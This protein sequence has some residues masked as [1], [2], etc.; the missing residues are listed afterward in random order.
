MDTNNWLKDEINK[1]HMQIK[2]ININMNKK[3]DDLKNII[4]EKDI[5]I[6]KL[7]KKLLK[8]K[9]RLNELNNI[10]IENVVNKNGINLK[11]FRDGYS[12]ETKIFGDKFVKN[13][14]DNIELM[15]NGDKTKLIEKAELHYGENNIKIILK[16]KLENLEEMFK[17]CNSLLNIEELKYLDVSNVKN[18]SYM[19]Y[20]CSRLSDIKSL[21]NWNV[22]N[23][24]NFSYMLSR[25]YHLSDIK[26]LENWKTKNKIFKISH[27][28]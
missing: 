21:K 3:E 25:R 5:L 6:K 2:E 12:W 11:Y 7:E 4:E 26:S 10:L 19:F 15:I 24:N 8:Q 16:N 27:I 23:G 17:G 22:S 1:I 14:Q 20:D 18:F 9:K 28:K 13:N